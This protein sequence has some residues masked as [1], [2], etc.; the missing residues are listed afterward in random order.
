MYSRYEARYSGS[1]TMLLLRGRLY[2][3]RR[4]L[5]RSVPRPEA[6][7]PPL[8]AITQPSAQWAS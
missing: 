8:P 4:G 6:M 5:G 1:F 2:A 3:R 7:P